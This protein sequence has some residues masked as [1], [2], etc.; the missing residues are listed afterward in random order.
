M[1][2]Q[3]DKKMQML[4]LIPGEVLRVVSHHLQFNL[5]FAGLV[6]SKGGDEK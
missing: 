5:C 6:A 1:L 4:H 3:E 2:T